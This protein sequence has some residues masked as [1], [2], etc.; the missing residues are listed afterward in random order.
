MWN[1]FHNLR[2]YHVRLQTLHNYNIIC[3]LW[4]SAIIIWLLNFIQLNQ[5]TVTLYVQ[6]I[7]SFHVFCVPNIVVNYILLAHENISYSIKDIS[8]LDIWICQVMLYGHFTKRVCLR[9]T[10]NWT[11]QRLL[12]KCP[13]DRTTIP[14][15]WYSN[16]NTCGVLTVSVLLHTASINALLLCCY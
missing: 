15:A 10:N 5:Y 9:Y 14:Y 2:G 12:C 4:Q 1:I 8:L 13:V 7:Q 16:D 11:H 3:R 6:C